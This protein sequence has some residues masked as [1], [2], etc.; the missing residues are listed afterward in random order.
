MIERCERQAD[1]Q[2]ANYGG[3]G[4][5]V[6][7]RWRNDFPAFLA[8]M[9]PRP[10]GTTLD[11]IN[12]DG[13]YEPS[14]CR[15]ATAKEQGRNRRNNVRYA[16][17]GES[18]TLPEWEERTGID[19]GVLFCRLKSGWSIERALTEPTRSNKLGP[20]QVREIRQRCAARERREDIARAFGVSKHLIYLISARKLWGHVADEPEAA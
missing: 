5:A 14:N 2:W 18:L 9:G 15:W 4:I 13:N 11:R 16:F 1:L 12:P 10:A 19:K 7:E 17:N 8:D 3:R 6:C 20:E